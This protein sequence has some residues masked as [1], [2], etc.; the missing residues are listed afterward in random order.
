MCCLSPAFSIL[1]AA[2]GNQEQLTGLD[3]FRLQ[4]VDGTDIRDGC[5]AGLRNIPKHFSASDRPQNHRR[6]RE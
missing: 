3:L 2:G 4:L 6:P 5:A 1:R